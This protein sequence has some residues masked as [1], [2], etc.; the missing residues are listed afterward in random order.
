MLAPFT[1]RNFPLITI[2]CSALFSSPSLLLPP[3][4]KVL[5]RKPNMARWQ[6]EHF[7]T[8]RTPSFGS[9]LPSRSIL[10]IISPL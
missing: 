9:C 5:S 10:T 4:V 6:R 7:S 8:H 1:I 2:C 3:P